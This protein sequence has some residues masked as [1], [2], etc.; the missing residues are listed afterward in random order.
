MIR[1]KRTYFLAATLSQRPLSEIRPFD[2]AQIDLQLKSNTLS[3]FY[4]SSPD[5]AA[6][7]AAAGLKGDYV[8]HFRGIT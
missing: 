6:P 7:G 1:I 4:S 3:P 8:V 2:V 5:F